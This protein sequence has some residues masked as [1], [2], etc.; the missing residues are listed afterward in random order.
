[1]TGPEGGAEQ[2]LGVLLRG[3][4]KDLATLY[5]LASSLPEI[6]SLPWA[7]TPC[8]EGSV[9]SSE[10]MGEAQI[11][12]LRALGV[13]F[14]AIPSGEG[15]R[16]EHLAAA[17]P[18]RRLPGDPPCVRA[19][20]LCDRRRALP[21]VERLMM[22]GRDDARVGELSMGEERYLLAVLP[23]PPA[24]LL[25]RAREQPEEGVTAYAQQGESGKVFVSYGYAH[26]ALSAAER[27]ADLHKATVLVDSDGRFRLAPA[28]PGLG[29]IY[30]AISPTLG[31]ELSSVALASTPLTERITL[32]VHLD[33]GPEQPAE[34]WLLSAAELSRLE[35][36]AASIPRDELASITVSRVQEGLG[37]AR[38]LLRE[39]SRPGKARIGPRIAEITG[40]MGYARVE[41]VDNLYL[42]CRSRI[43]PAL[44]R[45]DLRAMLELDRHKLAVLTLSEE[46]GP[47]LLFADDLAEAPLSSLVELV[48]FDRRATLD[49]ML[50]AALLRFPGLSVEP[51]PAPPKIELPP[52]PKTQP[53]PRPPREARPAPPRQEAAEESHGEEPS[54][55][56]AELRTQARAL[57]AK[58]T[59]GDHDPETFRALSVVEAALDALHDASTC[60]ESVIFARAE[61][62]DDRERLA[63]WRAR[64]SEPELRELDIAALSLQEPLSPASLS[65]LGAR[66]LLE[67]ERRGRIEDGLFQHVTQI[68]R[69]PSMPVAKRLAW[70][71]LR[72]LHELSRDSLGL[73][74]AKEGLLGGLNTAGLAPTYDLPIFV[75]R[76]LALEGSEASESSRLADQLQLLD[77]LCPE[78]EE[79]P[80]VRRKGAYPPPSPARVFRLAIFASGFLRIGAASRARALVERAEAESEDLRGPALW[81]L[82]LYLAR[83]QLGARKDVEPAAWKAECAR[84]LGSEGSSKAIE[85]FCK[86]SSWLALE[87]KV[88]RPPWVR[89]SVEQACV[90]AESQPHDAPEILSKVVRARENYDYEVA[91]AIVRCVNAALATGSDPLLQEIVAVT[92]PSVG[93]VSSKGQRAIALGACVRAAA[94]ASDR[95][96][97]DEILDQIV[98][99]T[100]GQDA[101]SVG[102]LLSAV[103]PAITALRPLGASDAALSF[104]SALVPAQETLDR[105]PLCAHL[106]MGFRAA[107]DLSLASEMLSRALK[108]TLAAKVSDYLERDAA[109]SA[110][111][112]ALR[113]WPISERAAYCQSL[114]EHAELFRD[115]FSV[116]VHFPTLQ[117]LLFERL[118]D[119]SIDAE[120]ASA[121]RVRAWLD[122]DELSIRR[123]IHADTGRGA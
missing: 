110:L 93:G 14:A 56:L 86:R 3:E 33:R 104:L 43:R 20:L 106:A 59:A 51:P 85:W 46:G 48:A 97:L 9:L 18:P 119:T 114:L 32:R 122:D 103:R 49:R 77:L 95:G 81:L 41:G 30:E 58:V 100:E 92:L 101:P 118:V 50:D 82:R 19:W 76:F 11:E 5:V 69:D 107:G 112:E 7:C 99:L 98:V 89:P 31:A 68:F 116:S 65:L 44:R 84:V 87:G 28:E 96:S 45:D 88:E 79:A 57:E 27:W 111:L 102:S 13:A 115:A 55:D 21:L 10:H 74:R 35:E 113:H 63:L 2:L 70:S 80:R 120:V 8:A 29:T 78:R 36:L 121:D 117:L 123:Q 38:Y 17:I 72:A 40:S 6:V 73:Q 67:I 26:P 1:M 94:A 62:P 90:Q 15:R 37:P 54:V 53:K 109:A 83:M 60:L 52:R 61:R 4:A 16:A 91:N 12:A 105:V 108:G 42:P 24:Y 34:L 47:T 22:L 39:R 71:V 64:L 75:R 25:M 23:H 66:L